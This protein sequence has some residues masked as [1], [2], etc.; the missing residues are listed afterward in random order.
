MKNKCYVS[1]IAERAYSVYMYIFI[2]YVNFGFVYYEFNIKMYSVV[3]NV[4]ETM[5][6][7]KQTYCEL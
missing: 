2:Q 3:K 6:S 4:I 7:W 5:F 1:N